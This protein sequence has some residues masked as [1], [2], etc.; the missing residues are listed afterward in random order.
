LDAIHLAHATTIPFENLDIL[1]GRPI[2]LDLVSLQD[3]L[4]RDRRGGYC[5]EHNTLLAAAL[6]AVGSA[7]RALERASASAP[8]A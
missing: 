7:S 6:E 4:V 8:G 3:K 2:R 1:L 5:F